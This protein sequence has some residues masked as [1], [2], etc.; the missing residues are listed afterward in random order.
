[1]GTLGSRPCSGALAKEAER[2]IRLGYPRPLGRGTESSRRRARRAHRRLAL[3]RP[4][5]LGG[6]QG[7][8]GDQEADG[9]VPAH[10]HDAS[11]RLRSSAEKRQ[12][13]TAREEL[14]LGGGRGGR[15]AWAH[16]RL[17]VVWC[18]PMGQGLPG[19]VPCGGGDSRVWFPCEPRPCMGFGPGASSGGLGCGGLQV[20][21]GALGRVWGAGQV[22]GVRMGSR[23][24]ALSTHR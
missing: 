19:C 7:W 24:S 20:C 16:T 13:V 9:D 17:E 18:G 23:S 21:S 2:E 10:A 1:M 4:S 22:L 5:S 14:V 12:R 6:D 3:R 11:V 15:A 8:G